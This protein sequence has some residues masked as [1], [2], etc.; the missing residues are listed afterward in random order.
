MEVSHGNTG[1]LPKGSVLDGYTALLD[2]L[3]QNG[4]SNSTVCF[5]CLKDKG[6][7][8]SQSTIKRYI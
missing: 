1:K 4:I 2:V 3:L 7:P 5:E 6:Y 8:G